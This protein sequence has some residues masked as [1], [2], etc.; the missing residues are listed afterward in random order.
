VE[1]ICAVGYDPEKEELSHE[2]GRLRAENERL[3][4]LLREAHREM[5]YVRDAE[6]AKP[7][8]L[9]SRWQPLLA[10][11]DAELKERE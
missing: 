9:A 4:G 7:L 11:I 10:R 8:W 3:R 2:N 1:H 6:Y 5:V